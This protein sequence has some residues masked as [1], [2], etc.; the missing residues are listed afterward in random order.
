M[1]DC[2]SDG[3]NTYGGSNPPAAPFYKRYQVPYYDKIKQELLPIVK[4]EIEKKDKPIREIIIPDTV[5]FKKFIESLNSNPVMI[6]IYVQQAK[7]TNVI[8]RDKGAGIAYNWSVNIPIMGYENSSTS[9]WNTNGPPKCNDVWFWNY[10]KSVLLKE[11]STEGI[12]AMDTRVP[13]SVNATNLRVNIL[14]RM[15]LG[16]LPK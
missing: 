16:W 11:Y 12:F 13:H 3:S 10:D 2:K 7:N 4:Q 14:C 5:Y 15:P 6:E 1:S 8:H 9:F